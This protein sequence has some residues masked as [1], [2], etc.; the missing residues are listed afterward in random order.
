MQ[1]GRRVSIQPKQL[2][3]ILPGEGFN[4]AQLQDVSSAG[5]A[6]NLDLSLL[7][8]AW[9]IAADGGTALS[10][11]E[12]SELLFEDTGARAQYVT[13]RMLAEGPIYFKQASCSPAGPMGDAH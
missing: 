6:E 3:L 11:S 9:E 5:T 7:E 1:G 4:E 8:I 2:S 13:H 10:L 12:L